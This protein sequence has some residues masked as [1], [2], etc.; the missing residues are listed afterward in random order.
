[1]INKKEYKRPAGMIGFTV[2]WAGQLISVLATSM[3]QFSMTIWVY[4]ETGSALA[5]GAVT[6]AFLL[7]F[8][9][10]SPIAGAMVDRYN[11][12]MM[13]MLSDL[14]SVFATSCLLIIYANGHLQVWHLYIIAGI[15]GVGST[16]QW[17]AYSAAISTMV[18]KDHYSR[19]NGMMSLIT[20]GPAVLAPMLAGLLLPI[21]QITGILIIDVL[22][23][24][25]AIGALSVVYVP[26]PTKTTARQEEQGDLLKE[27]LYGFKYIFDRR[28]LLGLSIFFISM[29]F[30]SGL[31]DRLLAPFILTRTNYNQAA[32]GAVQSAGAIGAVIGGLLVS[33]WP[34]FK[35]R[36][37]NIFWGHALTG[38]FGLSLFGLGLNL[39]AWIIFAA[40]G[41]VMPVY[42][43]GSSQAIWQAKVAPDVQ[44]RVFAARRMIAWITEPMTPI[45][46]GALADYVTEPAMRS[47]GVLAQIFG[48]L[49]GTGP[50]S[51]MAVQFLLA[52]ICYMLIVLATHTFFPVIRNLED[53]LPDHDQMET[54]VLIESAMSD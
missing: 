19:A 8:L 52:G 28:S 37:N 15:N 41:N 34:G 24:L 4:R 53:I 7:P 51:G 35:R 33:V 49:V 40:L 48:R 22:T 50:G 45:L 11:R 47:G 12:K 16:F 39:P 43:F 6:T 17:P 29:N 2:V 13:M 44:G 20:S 32:L 14:L 18:P 38:L 27:G 23:F 10:L 46:A 3:T 26:Q 25:L 1:M 30:V 31:A 5:L 36:I 21:V 42:A 9:L 54:A